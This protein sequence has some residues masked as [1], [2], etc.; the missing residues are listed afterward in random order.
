MDSK[1]L[2][3]AQEVPTSSKD[4]SAYIEH[5]DKP[6][7]AGIVVLED[8]EHIPVNQYALTAANNKL[9]YF[10]KGYIL[11]Y[12][13][14]FLIYFNSTM[15]GYD[16]SMMASLNVLPEYQAYFQLGGAAGA[17]SIVFA[18]FQVGQIAASFFFWPMDILGRKMVIFI[19]SIGVIVSVIIQGTAQNI[20]IFI[21]GRF[22]GAF[23]STITSVTSVVYLVEIAPPLH[24]GAVAGM[25]NTLYYCGALI[26]SFS[27]YGS[28]LHHS[29][30]QSAWKIPVFLQLMCPVIVAFFIFLVPE[31]PR[32]LVMKGRHEEA[33]RMI[34][35]Y[36]ANGDV[37]HPTVDLELREIEDSITSDHKKGTKAWVI[38]LDFR[39]LFTTRPRRYRAFLAGFM[40]WAGEFSGA[41]IASYYL[42]VMA[43]KVGIKDNTT[44]LLLT[45]MYFV[46]CWISAIIG[47]N[48]HDR[49][50]RRKLLGSSMFCLSIIFA[51]MAASTATYEKNGSKGSSYTMITFIFLFGIVFSFA[52]TPMQP[53]YPAEVLENQMRARGIA[54]FGFNAGIAGFINTIAGQVALDS[55]SYNFYTF[56]A[57]LDLLLFIVI[58]F[59]FVETKKR[60]MEE[61][62]GVF[63]AKNPRKASKQIVPVR[64]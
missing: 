34:V 58:Y 22:L 10:G 32:W 14:C 57:V 41:N 23:F 59:F 62:E 24:R 53:V 31:S 18:I 61:L 51:V 44:L 16:G 13:S 49:F 30:T 21:G 15:K 50:G 6:E 11:L 42:P 38:A 60:T 19:C 47:A 29:G 4:A 27:A 39:K 63:A 46:V 54:F 25:F 40:G 9:D 48:M 20:S 26:A 7:V 45:S 43:K 36:H 33:K 35:K 12:L 37:S 8:G 28:S 56:Y 5:G 64:T 3:Q 1:D 55:I 17:T 52:W 2:V